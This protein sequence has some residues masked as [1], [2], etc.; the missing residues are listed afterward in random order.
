[1]WTRKNELYNVKE[2]YI[3]DLWTLKITSSRKDTLYMEEKQQYD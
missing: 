3:K 2:I 1:M